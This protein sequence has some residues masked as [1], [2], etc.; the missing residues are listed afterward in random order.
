MTF[1]TKTSL[2]R[3]T[4]LRGVG[5]TL[6]LPFLDSMIP[7]LSAATKPV[8]RLGWVYVGNGMIQN[9]FIPAA[10]GAAFDLPPILKP[11]EK[12][13]NYVNVISGLQHKQAD[14]Q[15]DGTGDH[16]RAAAAWLTGVH[17]RD[18]SQPGVEVRL[19]A[20]ADQLAA[21]EIGKST[22]VPSMELTVDHPS[23]GACDAGD[24]FYVNTVSWRNESTPNMPE[25]H[26]RVVFERLF[27][28]GGTGAQRLARAKS[29]GSI[30]DSVTQEATRLASTL[31]PNDRNKLGE[32]FDSVREIELRIHNAEAQ[33]EQSLELPDRP[34]GIPDSFD[35]YVNM[36]LDLQVLALRADLTRV[37][38][39]ILARELSGRGYPQIGVPDAHHAVSHHRDDPALVAKKARIDTYH[40]QIFS[41]LIEKMH[42]VP[43]VDGS[44]LD[45]SLVM[46]GGGLGNGNL[47]RHQ[48]LPCLLVGKQGG[49]FK[50]GYH[51]A[52]PDQPPMANLLLTIL[53]KAGVPIEKLGDS[54]GR[55]PL[56]PLSVAI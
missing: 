54:T 35:D 52:Y 25:D 8:A 43:D 56:E 19:A 44:L 37:F 18:R 6:A 22:Q 42:A 41:R 20:T 3:R 9:Q 30:L 34:V 5:T 27:G 16:P 40:V 7:A 50:T 10:T 26:P 15:G 29:T 2:R 46:Y 12:M 23:Q 55:L 4:F 13:R 49:K 1:I 51:V 28:D 38:T 17:A 36:M 33:G 39:F 53:D 45:N 24:C 48:N 11:I 14:T 32:Y 31:G 21:R 47:H